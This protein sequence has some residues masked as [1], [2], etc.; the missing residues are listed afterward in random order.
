MKDNVIMMNMSL[1]WHNVFTT[2]YSASALSQ[3]HIF[4]MHILN[5]VYSQQYNLYSALGQGSCP[6]G[7]AV[8]GSFCYYISDNV[9]SWDIAR[10]VCQNREADLASFNSK[11]E[12][13]CFVP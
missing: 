4:S 9:Y 13:V 3:V 5:S 1:L 10:E 6:P 7:W 8:F 12:R 11:E 2:V